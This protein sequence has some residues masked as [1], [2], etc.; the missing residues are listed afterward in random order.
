M[1]SGSAARVALKARARLF[2]VAPAGK[3]EAISSAGL[4]PGRDGHVYLWSDTDSGREEAEGWMGAGDDLWEVDGRGLDTEE[5]NEVLE[6]DYAPDEPVAYRFRGTIDPAR[7][8]LRD[9]GLGW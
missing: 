4:V 9:D 7:L 2:H 1:R 5:W 8:T 6:G 3:R